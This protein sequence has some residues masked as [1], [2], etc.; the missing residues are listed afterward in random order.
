MKRTFLGALATLGVAAL[1][2]GS[3][4]ALPAAAQAVPTDTSVAKGR[5]VG[6]GKWGYVGQFGKYGVFGLGQR[7][8]EP[9]STTGTFFLPYGIDVQG[10]EIAV[11]DSGLA[12]WESGNK[13]FGHAVHTFMKTADPGAAGHGD[14]LGA[15]QYDIRTT[16]SD[17]DDP[18][19]IVDPRAI[20]IYHTALPRGPR[21]VAFAPD[22]SVYTSSF[23]A[24][25]DPKTSLQMRQYAS[26]DLGEPI[27]MWGQNYAK[28]PGD[29]PGAVSTDT[30]AAGNVYVGT[31]FGVSV[32]SASGAFLSSVGVYFDQDGANQADRVKWTTRLVDVP[33][34]YG[35]PDLIGETYGLSVMDQGGQTVVY[36]GDAGA[37]Y[38]PDYKVHFQSGSTAQHTKPASIKKY[39]L[40]QSGGTTNERWNPQG[41]KWTLDTS[42]GNAGAVQFPE[43]QLLNIFNRPFFTGQTV[44]ALE[45]DPESGSLYYSLNGVAGKKI[46]ALD[47]ATGSALDAPVSLNSPSRQQDSAMNYVRGLAVDDRG[48]LYATTQDRTTESTTR[49]IVQIWGKTPSSIADTAAADPA[50]T[51]ATL[52]WGEST[53]GYQQPDLLD[54]VVQYRKVGDADWI[55]VAH[56][57]GAAT[58][59]AT[60]ADIAGLTPGT[61]YEA[62][63]TPYNEAGSGDPAYITWRTEDR[64]AGISVAKTGNGVHT[65]SADEA[66][67]VAAG[68][69]VTF[70][71][72]VTNTGNVPVDGVALDDSVLGSVAAPDDFDGTLDPQEQ[73]IFTVT[74]P[75]AAGDYTNTATATAR[76]GDAE[77]TATDA[78]YGF[79]V[80]TG[81]EVE[82]TGDGKAA[83]SK[84]DAIRV[85]AGAEVTFSYR[86]T[87]T[88]NTEV[89]GLALSDSVL[90]AVTTATDPADFAGT[91]APGASVTFTAK[92]AVPEGDYHNA[93]TA[94][95]TV[96]ALGSEV[97]GSADWYG[98]GVGDGGGDGGGGGGGGSNPPENP[99]LS[100]TGQGSP[101]LPLLGGAGLLLAGGALL[102]LRARIRGRAA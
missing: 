6:S 82:K 49:A 88:G 4:V 64:V 41:W 36:V 42:F 63:I 46:G 35:K 29:L 65:A 85:D 39:I 2:L 59:T 57:G 13:A 100:N 43:N 31:N 51:S 101:L 55:T 92:G 27:A 52:T 9:P 22:Q 67:S 87:N 83:A 25:G 45:A 19:D 77:L 56:P 23:E 94:T 60:T 7:V 47:L 98:I 48:L 38:Q 28:L 20:D 5:A 3:I 34:E 62:Q 40:T 30:D 33:R 76:D 102:A 17:T 24:A 37:Y 96:T 95:G 58:S 26:G 14:Y 80:T 69:D 90:G 75:V 15:G 97:T 99:N 44:F 12:S 71:Y 54:Y 61:E 1:A 70:E 84:D 11:T 79:G 32:Q 93:A 8:A 78:W 91:L 50:L 81:L 53:V 89:A 86:V 73:V 66:V 21:G 10:D 72:T 16:K 68:A 18:A 74:G